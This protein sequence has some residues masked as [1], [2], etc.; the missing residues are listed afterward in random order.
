MVGSRR[1]LLALSGGALLVAVAGLAHHATEGR[2]ARFP[3]E[4][5]LVYLPRTSVLRALSLGH[6]E[7]MADLV[8]LRTITYFAGQFFGSR[9][10]DWLARHVDAINELDP[11]FRTAYLFGARSAMYNGRTITNDDVFTSNHFFAKGLE[12]FPSDWEMAF[13]LGCNYLVELRTDDPAQRSAWRRQALF[14]IRRA[15]LA[16]GGPPWL[17]NLAAT[18]MSEEGQ[19]EASIRY[20]EE[21]Y[22]NATDEKTRD[23]VGRLLAARRKSDVARLTAARDAFAAGWKRTLPYAPGDL[24][25]IV[26]E[27][28]SLRLDWRWLTAQVMLGLDDSAEPAEPAE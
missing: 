12:R 11:W 28:P 24:Y 1:V 26:G 27:S 3:P 9:N 10:Y 15:A 23:E 8:F 20:L 4:E 14:W 13:G 22:L 19:V 21:A 5:D 7:A 17:P 18:I 2:R 6:P 16:G 25:V